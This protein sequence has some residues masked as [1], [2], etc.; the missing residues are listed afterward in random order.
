MVN[1]TSEVKAVSTYSGFRIAVLVPMLLLGSLA[2]AFGAKPARCGDVPISVNFMTPSSAPAAI[3][4]DIGSPYTNGQDGV[5]AVIHF[6][7][8]CDGSRDA[9]LGLGGSTRTLWMQFPAALPGSLGSPAPFAGGP[10]FPSQAFFNIHNV[11]GYGLPAGTTTYYTKTSSTFP[12]PDGKT[13][14][15]ALYPDNDSCPGVC[16]PVP[17]GTDPLRNQPGEEAWVKVTRM[18]ADTWLVEGDLVTADPAINRARLSVDGKRGSTINE[19]Q[20]SMPFKVEIKTLAP[21][22]SVP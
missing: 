11:L 2:T 4:N 7:M 3:W 1:S 22:P 12:G 5:G 21:L 20:Y 6:N 9:T 13:Y 19:G 8:S 18:T 17:D 16:A 10:A 14:H 15:L